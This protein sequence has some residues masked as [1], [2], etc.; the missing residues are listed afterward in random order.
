L[1]VFDADYHSGI[2]SGHDAR[3]IF[4]NDPANYSLV[5]P[6]HLPHGSVVTG[7]EA[8]I[9]DY[10]SENLG[11][12][13]RRV[14]R[15]FAD[16]AYLA[17]VVSS[18]TPGDTSISAGVI[19]NQNIDNTTFSYEVIDSGNSNVDLRVIGAVITY[20]LDEAP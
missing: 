13:L 8:V 2:W 10:D 4:V 19:F 20:T 6:V 18:G 12:A 11:L 17:S 15:E 5:A 7:F 9:S 16:W 14:R 1:P 3:G